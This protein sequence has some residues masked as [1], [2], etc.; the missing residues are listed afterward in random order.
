ML[1]KSDT[2]FGLFNRLMFYKSSMKIKARM[3]ATKIF[4]T[5]LKQPKRF[6][7]SVNTG[8]HSACQQ[9]PSGL[10]VWLLPLQLTV[11]LAYDASASAD[12]QVAQNIVHCRQQRPNNELH[13]RQVTSDKGRCVYKTLVLIPMEGILWDV[14]GA[15][16]KNEGI[17]TFRKNVLPPYSKMG[18][19]LPTKPHGNAANKTAIK[20]FKSHAGMRELYERK[21]HSDKTHRIYCATLRNV[22]H[23]SYQMLLTAS[24]NKCSTAKAGISACKQPTL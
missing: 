12:L 8:K 4:T 10:F 3:R 21:Y 18:C 14:D 11:S 24:Q 6:R 13:N 22:R 23:P 7:T 19:C 16:I 9:A 20:N 5:P 1:V 17:P 15:E 2:Y